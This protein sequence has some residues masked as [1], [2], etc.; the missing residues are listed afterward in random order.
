MSTSTGAPLNLV[1][2]DAG[3]TISLSVLNSNYDSINTTAADHESRLDAVEPLVTAATT[4]I[5]SSGSVYNST[6][7]AG[8]KL[9]VQTAAP[10]SGMVSG[11][12]WL[13]VQA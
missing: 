10:T 11:D 4:A 8:R 5:G 7:W 9:Y 13:K 2:P 12:V 6:R 1:K 3:D